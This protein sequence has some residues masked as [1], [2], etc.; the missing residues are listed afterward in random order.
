MWEEKV[1]FILQLAVHFPKK[2]GQDFLGRNLEAGADTEAFVWG[3]LLSDLLPW[4]D[5]PTFL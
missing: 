5:Q 3:V 4:F 1:Y 2:S